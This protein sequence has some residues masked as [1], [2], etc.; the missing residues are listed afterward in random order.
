M[1]NPITET[2]L[3]PYQ[4]VAAE[5]IAQQR[6]VLLADQPGLGKTLEVIGGLELA[7]LFS[8]YKVTTNIL[9]LTPIVNARTT[10]IDAL[11]RFVAPHYAIN[12]IDLSV[13]TSKAKTQRLEADWVGDGINIVV[14]NHNALDYSRKGW[15]VEFPS[16]SWDAVIVDE[17]HLVLPIGA[18]QTN[19]R[20]ALNKLRM[21]HDGAI[22][23]AISGTPDRGKLEN[24]F[25][26]WSFL[27]PSI[28]GMNRYAWLE[29]N[30]FMVE[31]R[32]SA[33]RT[34]RVPYTLKDERRWQIFS[35]KWMIRRTKS[36]VLAQL[37]PKRYI[38]VELD[39]LQDQRV[40]Y[41]MA[42][43]EFE[44]ALSESESNSTSAAMLFALRSRQIAV[45][46]WREQDNQL[47]PVVGGA[48][49]KLNW[50]LEWLDERGFIVADANADNEA[51]VVIVSQFSRVLHWLKTELANQGIEAQV[52]DG[53]T[54]ATKRTEIQDRFQNGNLR[55]VL[56]SGSMG[57]GINLDKADDLIML[58]SPYDPDRIEQIED[59][60]HRASSIHNVT[61]W[62]LM[63]KSTIDVSIAE[64]VSK[65]YQTTRKLLDEDRGVSI[66]RDVLK[67]I[68][69]IKEETNE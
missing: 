32:V 58:D 20:T 64:T 26:T 12:I 53:K 4:V 24:R 8:E 60:V 67:R 56:L 19:F 1:T 15:R 16:V 37:P 18:K 38:D 22:R 65:R 2:I 55:I 39:L 5:R 42:Q 33:N 7:G 47:L 13:G 35:N 11:E 51:K 34:I 52:L 54:S 21:Y 6:A 68:K 31:Q 59:R 63:A 28:V 49:I 36:E 61:I 10:W 23:I 48:S 29:D 25:G 41:L 30:F 43:M 57:V 69:A 44:E 27:Y 14:A 40:D 50:L 62:N 3:F 66:G 46:Q 17:S 9:V 45:C